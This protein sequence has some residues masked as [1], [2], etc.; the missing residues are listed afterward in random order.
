[1]KEVGIYR[2]SGLSSDVQKLKKAFE[3]SQSSLLYRS[4]LELT[5]IL[6]NLRSI[7]SGTFDERGGHSCGHRSIEVISQGITRIFIH[8]RVVQKVFRRFQ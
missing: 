7:R 8:K 2:V 1:M 3:T 5:Q 4:K 6:C